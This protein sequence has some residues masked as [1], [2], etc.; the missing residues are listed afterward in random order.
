MNIFIL[1]EDNR[2]SVSYLVT[3]HLT[4]MP[5]ETVQVLCSPFE[6]GTAPYKRTHINHPCCRWC[7][8][9]IQNYEWLL[10]Y[11]DAI[12][13]EFRLQR[14]KEHASRFVLNWCKENYKSLGLPD[15][16]MTPFAQAMPEQYKQSNTVKAYRDYYMGE[17]RHIAQWKNE[18]PPWWM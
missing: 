3:S 13:D 6:N 14:G 1:D 11:G 12:F 2:K 15:K 7:R 5:L 18:E 10:D 9:S 8:E 4:K 17:K 16:G